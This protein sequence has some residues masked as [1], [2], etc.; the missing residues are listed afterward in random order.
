MG[1]VFQPPAHVDQRPQGHELC[2]NLIR[3]K[4]L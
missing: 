4:V 2:H 1:R 3:V